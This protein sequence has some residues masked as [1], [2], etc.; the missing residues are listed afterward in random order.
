MFLFI[1]FG[2]AQQKNRHRPFDFVCKTLLELDKI[3]EDYDYMF[4]DEGQDFPVSFIKLCLRL[5]KGGRIV[6]A[7]DELQT[8]FQVKTPGIDKVLEGT[9]YKGLEEDIILY[10]CYR[11]PREVL[12]S[13][14]AIGFG[15]YGNKIVQMLD[16][17]EYWKDIGYKVLQGDFKEGEKIIIERPKENSLET[18]SKHFRKE[19]I[20][21][22]EAHKDYS[23]EIR[24]CMRNI[25]NDIDLGLLPDDILV[26]VVDDRNAKN[27]LE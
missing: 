24:Q 18:I 7:Y 21:K 23:N 3:E 2:R 25:K 17:K 8:I 1:S 12:V 6:W 16:E 5:C 13:A 10:K 14:H 19:E 22:F 26:I 4:I 11:N 20:V 15:I 9:K 27:I